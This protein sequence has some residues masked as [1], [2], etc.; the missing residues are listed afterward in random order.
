MNDDL[1][2]DDRPEM[3]IPSIDQDR[4]LQGECARV[5]LPTG[6]VCTL[7]RHHAGSCQFVIIDDARPSLMA[8]PPAP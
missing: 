3:H 4:A 2:R 7:Q 5:Y 6:D 8:A 1:D